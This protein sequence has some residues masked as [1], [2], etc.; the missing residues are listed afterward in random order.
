[1]SVPASCVE[2]PSDA[3]GQARVTLRRVRR[4]ITGLFMAAGAPAVCA[5]TAMPAP[6]PPP[7][8]S[9]YRGHTKRNSP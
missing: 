4:V 7:S 9:D 5:P 1:M 3:Q 6:R 8:P 2:T